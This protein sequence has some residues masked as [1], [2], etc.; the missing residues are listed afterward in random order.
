MGVK[1]P[2]FVLVFL[3]LEHAPVARKRESARQS[4]RRLGARDSNH[5]L[6]AMRIAGESNRA[7]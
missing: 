7:T 5:D 6:L 4:V 1:D 2:C 3:S